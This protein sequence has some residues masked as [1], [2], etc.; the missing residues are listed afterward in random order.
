MKK[1]KY[2]RSFADKKSGAKRIR[3]KICALGPAWCQARFV[4]SSKNGARRSYASDNG[5]P[6]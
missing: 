4:L 3:P 1:K 2:S 6:Y 5:K